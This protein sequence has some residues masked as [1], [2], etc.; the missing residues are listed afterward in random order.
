MKL[1][2]FVTPSDNS[3]LSQP[4]M[5]N[6]EWNF[7]WKFYVM[8]RWKFFNL[9]NE[10]Q[11]RIF[12]KKFSKWL[13]HPKTKIRE[14]AKDQTAKSNQKFGRTFFSAMEIEFEKRRD[15]KVKKTLEVKVFFNFDW[16]LKWKINGGSSDG[17]VEWEEGWKMSVKV[18]GLW[19]E[20]KK[21]F[22][23]VFR[24]KFLRLSPHSLLLAPS[25]FSVDF[26]QPQT[27]HQTNQDFST[28]NLRHQSFPPA[29][30]NLFS[31]RIPF[32][33]Q[34]LSIGLFFPRISISLAWISSATRK[35]QF[36]PNSTF[37]NRQHRK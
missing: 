9:P 32:K 13:H 5:K 31:V 19:E 26:Y 14:A 30:S 15:G 22:P 16:F 11:T 4:V 8:E 3:S 34:Q 27:H 36:L 6:C 17:G 2:V 25:A 12:R 7:S 10:K 21:K 23:T 24:S 20:L 33:H 29:S 1:A 18:F 28:S 37:A 35:S